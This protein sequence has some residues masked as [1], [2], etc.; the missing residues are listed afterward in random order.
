LV[1]DPLIG[2]IFENLIVLECLK[3]RYNQAL[4]PS[5]YFY[6]DKNKKEIDIVHSSGRQITGIEVKSS[7]TYHKDYRKQLD[8]FHAKV[9][10]LDR[11]MVI[12]SGAELQFS[13][14]LLVENFKSINKHF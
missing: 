1:R 10:P 11:S 5:L 2:S 7:K 13:D 12:Y 9:K 8:Y 14:G 3:S 4:Q 6:R